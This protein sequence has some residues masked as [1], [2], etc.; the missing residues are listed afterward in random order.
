VKKVGIEDSLDDGVVH[1]GATKD[2][3]DFVSLLGEL[4][5]WKR[6]ELFAK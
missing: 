4:R 2:V 5:L 3:K 6:E 1:L